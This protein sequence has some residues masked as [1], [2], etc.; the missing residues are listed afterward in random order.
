[1]TEEVAALM[2]T[3][4]NTL[5]I[6]EDRIRDIAGDRA[7]EGGISLLRRCEL[8]LLRRRREA[9]VD[10]YRRHAHES[11]QDFFDTAWRRRAGLGTRRG[12]REARAFPPAADVERRADGRFAL[13]FDRPARS[14]GCGRSSATTACSCAPLAYIA[15]YGNRIGDVARGAV[16]NANYI[17][18]GLQRDYHL[19]YDAPTLHEIVFSD[20]R[21]GER[22]VHAIDI[23]KRLMDYGFHP[24]TIY[25]PLIV[26]GA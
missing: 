14:A 6:F 12:R 21:Q 9:R 5:G 24:P 11:A 18:A 2:L 16:L 1:M 15:A 19:K 23:A 20:K 17:R 10:G 4:P 25:F 7:R 22:G 3:V 26:P 8:Q 13:D